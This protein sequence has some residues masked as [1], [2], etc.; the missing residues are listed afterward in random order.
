MTRTTFVAGPDLAEQVGRA[1]RALPGAAGSGTPVWRLPAGVVRWPAGLE[2]GVPG[3]DLVI[4][5]AET[6][7]VVED[8]SGAALRLVGRRVRLTGVGVRASG[9]GPLVGVD[10][11][12]EASRLEDVSLEGLRG[13][14]VTAL[15]IRGGRTRIARLDVRDVSARTGLAAGVDVDVAGPAELDDSRLRG[16]LGAR[17]AA[18][19]VGAAGG[20]VR[21]VAVSDLRPRDAGDDA[22]VTVSVAAALEVTGVR[23]VRD[24][25]AAGDVPA[26]LVAAQA[27]LAGVPAGTVETWLLPAGP[28]V[29]PAGLVLGHAGRGLRLRGVRASGGAATEVRVGVGAPV[30]GDLVA[31]DFVGDEVAVDELAVRAECTGRLTAVRVTS[32]R[33]EVSDLSLTRLRGA[34]VTGL[35]VAA[36]TGEAGVV[37]LRVED[38]VADGAAVGASVRAGRVVLTRA[39]VDRVTGGGPVRGLAAAGGAAVAASGVTAR[40][41]TGEGAQGVVLRATDNGAGLSAL[42]AVADGVTGGAGDAAGVLLVS[43]GSV[44]ARGLDVTAV[45]GGRATGALLAAAEEVDWAVGAVRDVR[46]TAGGAAG[47]RVLAR[48]SGSAVRLAGV[49]VEAVGADEPGGAARPPRSWS[50]LALPPVSGPDWLADPDALPL[51]DATAAGHAEDVAGLAVCA[52]VGEGDLPAGRGAGPVEVTGCVLRRVSGTALQVEAE[53]R[54]VL[55]RGVEAWT[56]VR[57]AW[58]DGD[59]VL[60]AQLTWH[61]LRTGLELGPAAATIVDVLVTDVE[62]GLPV[63]GGD[64][65]DR[66][67]ASFAGRSQPPPP[68]EP[69]PFRLAPL[70]LAVAPDLGPD[71]EVT[72][73]YVRPGPRTP[74][75]AAVVAGGVAAAA[76]V[77][78]RLV[79]GSPLHERAVRVPGDEEGAAFLG[80]WPGT[81]AACT[82]RDPLAV[83][84]PPPEPPVTPGPLVDY[85]ARDARSLLAVML[86]RARVVMP[87]W[88]GTSP[89][90]QTRMVMELLAHRLDR[91]AYRQEVAVA[92]GYVGTALLRR[93]LEDHA[94]LVD[95]HVDPGLSATALLQFDVTPPLDAAGAAPLTL[96]RDTVVVNRDPGVEPVVFTTEDDLPFDPRMR[97]VPLADDVAPGDTSALLAGH[98][99]VPRGRWLLLASVDPTDPAGERTDPAGPAHVVRVVRAEAAGPATRVFWD[100][101]RAAPAEFAAASTRVCGN[102]VPAHHGV[103]LTPLGTAGPLGWGNLGEVLRPWREQLTLHVDNRAGDVREVVVPHG[104]VSVQAAGWPFPGEAETRDGRPRVDVQ[105]DGEPWRLV[106]SL[107]TS[108][109][110]DEHV[111][112]RTADDGGVALR[113]GDGVSGAALP[114]AVVRL[115]VAM[116]S[117]R[118]GRGNVGAGVLTQVLAFGEGGDL[119]GVLPGVPDRLDVLLGAVRVDNPLPAVGGRDPEPTERIRARAPLAARTGL[120]AVVPADYE[121]ILATRR[122]VAGARARHRRARLRD[123][124]RVT[125]LLADEDALTAV[126]EAGAAERLRRWVDVRG[127]LEEARLLGTDVEVSPPRFVPLDVDVVVDASPRSAAEDVRRAVV[128]ALAGPGGLFDPDSTGLGGDVRVDEVYRRVLRVPGVAAARLRRLRRLHPGAPDRTADGVLPV[129]ADEVAVL[130]DPFGDRSRDGVL[131]VT[132]CGG[133]S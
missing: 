29:L 40:R 73:L 41:V 5:G 108:G 22:L 25:R 83:A 64:R 104:P 66:A 53:G 48:P 68:G 3:S 51:P 57:G 42:R 55:V 67:L 2:L 30:A 99:D 39:S 76:D 23:A 78:L 8:A 100:F 65:G 77:D 102:V 82:L 105:V 122:D 21:D 32:P 46:G 111:A 87:E 49:H 121:R 9:D 94:R 34:D 71:A 18:V 16:L 126:G 38:V 119:E 103:P 132:V 96:P 75:P 98:L 33:A 125:L 44:A 120:S 113:F 106:D 89:A 72:P 11:D 80:A 86:E 12:A 35:D 130:A 97:S 131:T 20:R 117:G 27:A 31:L 7:L 61:R 52:P 15:R 1:A 10:V 37:D 54:P 85:L 74:L 91:H 127:G 59:D 110:L 133:M 116:R 84:P 6:T 50:D 107:V 70:V 45:T 92:E 88:P 28:V 81:A 109:P 14:E 63:V 17:V 123:V 128:E 114:R 58:V 93:S 112:L 4:E 79:P 19:R 47:A 69:P 36:G 95:H 26:A 13:S 60:L 118:G 90:D 24:L 115:D 43:A 62:T 101:R 124:V 56:A 129:A